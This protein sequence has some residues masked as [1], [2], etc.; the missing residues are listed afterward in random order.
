MKRDSRALELQLI[1]RARRHTTELQCYSAYLH[2]PMYRS[3]VVSAHEGGGVCGD[4]RGVMS[5][6]LW[7]RATDPRKSP[8]HLPV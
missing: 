2:S 6:G 4:E 7:E 1:L 3:L 8:P 5:T